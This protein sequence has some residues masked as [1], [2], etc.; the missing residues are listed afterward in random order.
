MYHDVIGSR[1]FDSSGFSGSW[2]GAI[3]DRLAG[4]RGSSPIAAAVVAPPVVPGEL[5]PVR[6]RAGWCVTFDDAV[7]ARRRW[8]G[9]SAA[10]DWR[11]VF[12]VTSSLIGDRAF[13]DAEGIRALHE[14]GHVIGS[15]SHTHPA[16]MSACSRER[17]VEEWRRSVDLLGE[18]VGEP[19]EAASV[20][21]GYLSAL[22]RAGRRPGRHPSA[23]RVGTGSKGGR[24]RRLR[25]GR[26]LRRHPERVDPGGGRRG[27]GK[28]IAVDPA[29][30]EL[31]TAEGGEAAR[32][33]RIYSGTHGDSP[34]AVDDQQ[35][36][37]HRAGGRSRFRRCGTVR[38]VL[39]CHSDNAAQ[40]RRCCR[41]SSPRSASWWASWRSTRLASAR[42][43]D[44]RPNSGDRGCAS[45][46]SW[47]S[48]SS[49][50]ARHASADRRWLAQA[51]RP[52]AR[53]VRAAADRGSRVRDAGSELGGD[54]SLPDGPGARCGARA[55]QDAAAAR[56]VRRA[57]PRHARHPPGHLP[58]VPQRPRLL[59]GPGPAAIGTVSARRSCG[60]TTASTR[61]PR[62]VTTTRTSTST[63]DSHVVIQHKVVFDNLDRSGGHHAPVPRRARTVDTSGTGIDR[64]GPGSA[65]GCAGSARSAREAPPSG[66]A[67]DAVSTRRRNAPRASRR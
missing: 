19:I 21:G 4:F 31:D 51:A 38:T 54:T 12:L 66:P 41:P 40:P 67:C 16:R 8:A 24:R 32:R 63:C 58:R 34:G 37:Q 20:P 55:L 56:R 23:L 13:L 14:A 53:R 45:S 5:R 6:A 50:R 44:S 49:Y 35:R 2:A 29:T 10:G 27:R 43:I 57:A 11:G 33:T 18:I 26:P 42:S 36:D 47:P 15:H 62:S 1:D 48:G 39:I 59:L 7:R 22:G 65:T 64:G 60:S 3:Q 25:A 17:I 9:S 28:R 46:T 52:A 61:V 30:G